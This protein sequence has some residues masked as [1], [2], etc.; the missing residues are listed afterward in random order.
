M[1]ASASAADPARLFDVIMDFMHFHGLLN[2]VATLVT[3][4]FISWLDLLAGWCWLASS[5][6]RAHVESPT[7]PHIIFH[8]AI[9]QNNN[10]KFQKK[11][12]NSDSLRMLATTAR[13]L[14]SKSR[15]PLVIL[16][17]SRLSPMT[18]M[19]HTKPLLA[20]KNVRTLMP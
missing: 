12:R 1:W 18:V 20:Y 2:F 9:S 16:M 8:K 5:A 13:Q 11:Q 6:A 14:L 7:P 4:L 17:T 3:P 15:A 10:F 19:P